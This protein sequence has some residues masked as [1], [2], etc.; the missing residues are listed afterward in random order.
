MKHLIHLLLFTGCIIAGVVV[1]ECPAVAGDRLA[2][3]EPGEVEVGG[4]IGRRID[5]TIDKNLLAIDV[6]K[7]FLERF[8]EKKAVARS[9][10]PDRYVGLGKM[11]DATV[12]FAAYG[13]DPKVIKLK[14][15]LIDELIK[16]QLPDGYMGIFRPE[17]RVFA[18]WDLHEMVYLIHGL[19]AD[20]EHFGNEAA[21]ESA[22]KLGDY[23]IKHRKG[24]DKPRL[25]GKLDT[26]RAFIK[27]SRATGDKK[28]LDYAVDGMD[29]R[30]WNRPV[31]G[32]AYTF[33]NVC[34]AQ[35]DLH[36]IKPDEKLLAQSKKVVDYLTTNDGLLVNGTCSHREG[37]RDN[38]MTVG[39]VGETC[40][41]AYLIR[42]LHTLLRIEGTPA[43]GDIM[44]R[45]IYNALFA[46]Q[47]PDGRR[48][49]YF[50]PLEGK[51]PVYG[52]DTY[53]CPNNFR[54][55]VAELPQMV[56]YR[57]ADGG[58]TVNLYAQSSA[59]VDLG[60]GLSVKV[61]QETD[62][63][64]SGSVAIRLDP[65]RPAE[66]PLRLRIPAWCEKASVSVNGKKLDRPVESGTFFTIK[67]QW[68]PGDRVQ[69]DMPMSWRLVRGRKLQKGRVA[70]LRGPMLYCLDPQRL[71]ATNP[72]L[73]EQLD[74]LDAKARRAWLSA[75][76]IGLRLDPRTL[77]EPV[78][79]TTV[80]PRGLACPVR[81]WSPG[82]SPT[83]PPDLTLL[84]TE[85]ADPAGEATYFLAPKGASTIDDE[86]IQTGATTQ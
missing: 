53:C 13:K 78:N 17:H 44:E 32:H 10:H 16:T 18:Y 46:A 48:L 7:L 1:F 12:S 3:I 42:L 39:S 28:Y 14:D 24:T 37:F 69:L 34:L 51:R 61:R 54:R 50:T 15:H 19:V 45:A 52:F 66:F 84:L 31:S 73:A 36:D 62:Y 70:V 58:L 60:K 26:E 75:I 65:S 80:R 68:K 40:A 35:L 71:V 27:L 9:P 83:Q 23:I 79:D 86:L 85:F 43:Y 33:M 22:R 57:S 72:A 63:P 8:R 6:D 59:D 82:K 76:V 49:R 55:I 30:N 74:S 81:A 41:T 4:P 5:L 11:I 47:L 67:R 2:V 21:L 29:L 64:N 77:G 38:Q 25:V 20:Y 56:Y